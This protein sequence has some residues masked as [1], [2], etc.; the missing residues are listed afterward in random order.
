VQAMRD[1]GMS[2]LVTG[3]VRNVSSTIERDIYNIERALSDFHSIKW[4]LVESDSEDDTV[5]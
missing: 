5:D 2:I 4:F 1:N 3:I